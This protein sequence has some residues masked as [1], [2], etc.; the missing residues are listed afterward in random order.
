MGIQGLAEGL[1]TGFSTADQAIS[2]QRELGLRE[3]AQQQQVKDADRHY[4]LAKAQVDW[5]KETDNRDHHYKSQRDRVRDAQW[6]QH[7][8]LAQANQH[9]ANA[10]VGMQ[11]QE[12]TMRQREFNFQRA[13]AERQQRLQEEMPVVQAWYQQIETSGQADPQLYGQISQDNPLHPARFF[14]EE[15]INNV[16]AINQLMPKVLAGELSYNDPA[17]LKV[18]DTVLAPHIQRNLDEVDPPSG[19]TIKRKAL[20]HLGLSEDGQF[21]IAGLNVTYSDG[22][23]ANKPLTEFG[24]ADAK[25]DLV[26]RIPLTRVMD[27]LRGYGQMVGQLNQPDKAR[28]I[29]SMINPPD[30]AAVRQESEGY[31][32]AMLAIG[33]DESQQL[34]ALHKDGALMDERQRVAARENIQHHAGQRRQ[35]VI[36][37][38]GMGGPEPSAEEQAELQTF[39]EEY[40]RNAG[41]MPD[42]NNPQ[43]QQFFSQWKQQRQSSGKE[44][45]QSESAK[46]SQS[47][48]A[49]DSHTA[50]QLR[51]MKR[52]N[53]TR[54]Q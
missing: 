15:A 35:Q 32:K 43:D 14:G 26:V 7:Y 31:R 17:V 46:P 25:D 29:A 21:V 9:T 53:E 40:R 41:V 27:E 51:E 20:A 52:L 11:A 30:K 47:E 49:S 5:R 36:Q 28:F 44:A 10:R 23:T 16:M 13:Q 54:Q 38:Y 50:Q 45:T 4:G 3:A 39:M 2:R 24:S 1:L 34:A 19:K 33:Q 48:P 12:L 8:G 6:D 22:T 18:M 42:M 37:L